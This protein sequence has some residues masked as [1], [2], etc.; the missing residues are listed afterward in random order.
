MKKW[1]EK[2]QPPPHASEARFWPDYGLDNGESDSSSSEEED[3]D[4]YCSGPLID[5]P[6]RLTGSTVGTVRYVPM[7]GGCLGFGPVMLRFWTEVWWSKT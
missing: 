5:L 1:E 2:R 7:G 4:D 3:L 6:V